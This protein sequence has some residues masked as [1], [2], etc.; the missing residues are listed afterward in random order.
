MSRE[1]PLTQGYF[2]IVDADDYERLNRYKWH[3]G[4]YPNNRVYPSRWSVVKSKRIRMHKDILTPVRGFVIDH[5]NGNTLDNRKDNLRI[6]T[7]SQNLTNVG[8]KSNNTSGY[9][10]VSWNKSHGKWQSQICVN[11]KTTYL[12]HF[13]DK[14]KA[15]KAYDDAALKHHGEFARLNF[16]E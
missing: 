2:A 14:L 11:G 15:A 9:K 5:I 4:V 3:V 6:C 1:I 13:N 16:P 12:G 8:K 7:H 10:G